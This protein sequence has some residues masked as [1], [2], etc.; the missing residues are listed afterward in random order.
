MNFLL[1]DI[2]LVALLPIS[3]KYTNISSFRFE[4]DIV[5]AS[6]ILHVQLEIM[7]WLTS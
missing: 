5:C 4:K 7:K 3:E 1:R 6:T 2:S